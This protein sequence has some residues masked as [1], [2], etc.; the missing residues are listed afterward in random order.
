MC[1]EATLRVTR[2]VTWLTVYRSSYIRFGDEFD[3]EGRR[4]YAWISRRGSIFS[5]MLISHIMKS[6]QFKVD[7][8]IEVSFIESFDENW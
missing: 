3:F 4:D 2:A 8:R 6:Y 5:E 7:D 1:G